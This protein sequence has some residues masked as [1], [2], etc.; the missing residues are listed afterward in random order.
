MAIPPQW[1]RTEPGQSGVSGLLRGDGLA[2][3]P[4]GFEGT[5]QRGGRA[6]RLN[7][8]A[9][10]WMPK[11]FAAPAAQTSDTESSPQG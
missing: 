1:V 4:D 9:R 8:D 2:I 7:Q 3:V 10:K 6:H 11:G 5:H